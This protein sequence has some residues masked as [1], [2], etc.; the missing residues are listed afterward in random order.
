[1]YNGISNKTIAIAIMTLNGIEV[2]SSILSANAVSNIA[3][4][5]KAV[6]RSC[7]WNFFIRINLW[8]S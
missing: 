7:D 4:E 1:M 8:F 5:V 3:N 2:H 6:G